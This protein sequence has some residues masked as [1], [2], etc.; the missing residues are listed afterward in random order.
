MSTSTSA[1]HQ[2]SPEELAQFHR[3]GVIG[4]FKLYEPEEAKA[5]LHAIRMKN[6][7]KTHAIHQNEVNYDRHFDI[8]ELSRHI[9]HPGIVG[10]VQGILGADLLCWRSEF[11]PKFPGAAGTEWHQVANYQYATGKPM[12]EATEQR[13]EDNYLDV[14]VWTAF[15]EATL[16]NG[17]MKFLPGS[18]RKVYYDES[19]LTEVGR[20]DQYVSVNSDTQFFGYDFQE[21]K[22]DPK[23]QP[24]ENEALTMRMQPGECV[25]FT[26]K[27][28]HASH[29][30]ITKRSTRFAITARYTPTHVRVYPDQ[31]RFQAHGGTFD[32][33]E[34]NY[35]AVLVSGVDN[36]GHNA[37]RTENNLGEPFPFV[38][39]APARAA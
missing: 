34:S 25:I 14:T 38:P 35:G 1:L 18:H 36:Y 28:V 30:N 5:M 29:P 16:E 4:P 12:L 2:L 23:W 17:C 31:S 10:R 11:F 26:A 3:D 8:P 37:I 13:G 9:A 22:V 6:L 32:L 33:T 24:D 7:D 21:F 15:T 19:K 27:C 20:Q 39:A